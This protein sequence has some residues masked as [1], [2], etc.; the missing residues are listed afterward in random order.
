MFLTY[1]SVARELALAL[2]YHNRAEEAA[3][4]LEAAIAGLEGSPGQVRERRLRLEADFAIV[5]FGHERLIDRGIER[6]DRAAAGLRGNSVLR[7]V[8]RWRSDWRAPWRGIRRPVGSATEE[9]VGYF[10]AAACI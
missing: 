8:R 3:A 2:F 6:L 7:R 4:V 9:A 1:R 10:A 5:S